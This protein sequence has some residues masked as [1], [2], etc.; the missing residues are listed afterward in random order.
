MRGRAAW[1]SP[2]ADQ[3]LGVGAALAW[4]TRHGA[5]QVHLLV[6]AGGTAARDLAAVARRGALFDPPV[7]VLSIDGRE[8]TV[9]HPSAPDPVAVPAP[10]TQE[11][12]LLLEQAGV[13]VV[14]DEGVVVGEILGLEVARV[15]VD[16][17]GNSRLEVGVGRFD[18]EAF[19]LLHGEL[20]PPE[21][22]AAAIDQVGAVRRPGAEPHPINRV[23]RERWLRH[24]LI[25]H[26]Q[27]V[28]AASLRPADASRQRSGLRDATIAVAAGESADGS[29]M[30]VAASVGVDLEAV[31]DAAD[32]RLRHAPEAELVV[33]VP[34][35]DDHS[36][37]RDLA[38][39]LARPARVVTVEGPWPA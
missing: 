23:A 33:V 14:V 12:R 13:E 21:A 3:P 5:N 37:T 16:A 22:L 17:D 1:I 24:H 2:P 9:V 26:P 30:V 25:E 29:P 10:S 32:A 39:M 18:R 20:S 34:P 36:I 4:A 6:E 15:V 11:Q 19:A 35:R 8:A 28:G 31:P 38:A 7:D 27:L